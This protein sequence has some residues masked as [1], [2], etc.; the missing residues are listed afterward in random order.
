MYHQHALIVAKS[1]FPN[2]FWDN[3]KNSL[4][5]RYNINVNKTELHTLIKCDNKGTYKVWTPYVFLGWYWVNIEELNEK[6][7]TK[8]LKD[9]V[10]QYYPS[11]VTK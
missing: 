9:N 7:L 4:L 11:L 8:I 2:S 1:I 5:I 6:Q 3:K 10:P